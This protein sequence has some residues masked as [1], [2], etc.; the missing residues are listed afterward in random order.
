MVTLQGYQDLPVGKVITRES[1]LFAAAGVDRVT[2]PEEVNCPVF[3]L[4]LLHRPI[5]RL[6]VRLDPVLLEDSPG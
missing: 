2:I 1:D 5:D 6:E 3:Q 4:S